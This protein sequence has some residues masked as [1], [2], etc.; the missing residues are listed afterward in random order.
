MHL[1]PTR[2][3][4]LDGIRALA[5][6]AV[7][8]GH[9]LS[10]PFPHGHLGVDV[11]FALSG[12]LITGMLWD[13][14][15]MDAHALRAFWARRFWRLT[16]ALLVVIVACMAGGW[17]W[18][19]PEE[20]AI[21]TLT[22]ASAAVGAS[23]LVLP[24]LG[25]YFNPDLATNAL[26]HTWSLGVEAQ[27][28]LLYPLLL[29]ALRGRPRAALLVLALLASSSLAHAWELYGQASNWAHYSPLARAWQLLAGGMLALVVRLWPPR[30]RPAWGGLA[31]LGLVGVL[32]SPFWPGAAIWP[33]LA[34][35]VLVAL[36]I[37]HLPDASVPGRWLRL[38]PVQTIGLASY[39]LYLWHTPVMATLRLWV[40]DNT[41][42]F[43]I[44]AL[45]ATAALGG[46][47]WAWIERPG[48]RAQGPVRAG[49]VGAAFG[50][51]AIFALGSAA[52]IGYPHRYAGAPVWADLEDPRIEDTK[53]C[54]MPPEP[55]AAAVSFCT[56][57]HKGMPGAPTLAVWGDSF[58]MSMVGGLLALP[59][60]PPIL[61][62]GMN[63][64]PIQVG[65]GWSDQTL[66]C[67]RR[68]ESAIQRVVGDPRVAAVVIVSRWER[69]ALAQGAARLSAGVERGINTLH[70]A[71]KTVLMVESTPAFDRS[72]GSALL[73]AWR[74]HT[75]TLPRRTLA[76]HHA[77]PTRVQ[78]P[79]EDL[80]RRLGVPLIPSL[81]LLCTDQDC[82]PVVGDTV[83]YLDEE[84]LTPRGAMPLAARIL[85]YT[86]P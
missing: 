30:P 3:H 75:D 55:G 85:S 62:L 61:H 12:Y 27:F 6:G 15:H 18:A 84:H 11:F 38:R 66:Q 4:A 76:E 41:L 8:L 73:R 26:M 53:T 58:A 1:P 77:W 23:P 13:A 71:G 48:Q 29:W 10:I 78:G 79:I 24:H 74:T 17:I 5:V 46:A 14:P 43:L 81:D 7:I 86:H 34:A 69:P 72:V 45:L 39:S 47:S 67:R 52:T 28:Y 20:L 51:I 63:A 70:A 57:P 82:P 22:G 21:T 64:C 80:A 65:D 9:A 44:A 16:P 54:G 68:H 25:D 56:F 50:A 40:P 42:P 32:A 36:A 2:H 49:L 59:A 60:H 83:R 33:H 37:P 31:V 19:T 35:V